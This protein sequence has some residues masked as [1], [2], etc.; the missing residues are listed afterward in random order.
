M[1]NLNLGLGHIG[2]IVKDIEVSKI[3]LRR[4]DFLK[5]VTDGFFSEVLTKSFLR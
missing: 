5:K 2:I 1:D 3:L 4:R